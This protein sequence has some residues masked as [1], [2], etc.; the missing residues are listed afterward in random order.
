[1]TTDGTD[2]ITD[3]PRQPVP[4]RA[5]RP[6]HRAE[7]VAWGLLLVAGAAA[8][9][10]S[11]LD[12]DFLLDDVGHIELNDK[13]R[14]LVPPWP[15][16]ADRRPVVAVSLAINYAISELDVFSFHVFNLL[17]H[18]SA[19]L[20]LMGVVRR[21]LLLD[22]FR[23]RYR[24]AAPRIAFVVALVWALHPVQTQAV[25]YVIQ[26]AESL[27]G[28]FYL[29]TF[30]GVLRG[31]VSRRRWGW[32]ALAVIACAL[33]MG[34]KV[35]MITAPG[36]LLI[37]D[38]TLMAGTW[39]GALRRR[40]SLYAALAATWMIPL[41]TGVIQGVLSTSVRAANVGF[42]FKGTSPVEYAITQIGVLLHYLRL[43]LWPQPLCLDYAWP[44]AEG[45]GSALLPGA[46]LVV[47]A[48]WLLVGLWRRAPVALAGLWFFVILAP[49]S[50]I[51]PIRDPLFEHRMYLPLA[52]VILMAVIGAYHLVGWLGQR[53]RLSGRLAFA[54]GWII[55]LA[56]AVYLAW[57]TSDRNEMYSDG[58]AMWNDVLDKRPQNPR[59]Y[60]SLGYLM[61]DSADP[62]LLVERFRKAVALDPTYAEALFNLGNAL[63]KSGELEE[64]VEA[65]REAL[66]Y[67]SAI[68]IA[69][70]NMG[71]ALIGL[72][73][74]DEAEAAYREA[75]RQ[76]PDLA[77]AYV[78]LG[79]IFSG[80][81]RPE[82]AI[83][84][85]RDALAVD[86]ELADAR[87]NLANTLLRLG[88]TDEAIAELYRILETHPDHFPTHMKLGS[89]LIRLERTVEGMAALREAVR[90]EPNNPMGYRNLG[91]GFAHLK[92]FDEA[93]EAFRQ[94]LAI[95]PDYAEAHYNLGTALAQQGDISAAID[96][97]RLAV[98]FNPYDVS[99]HLNLGRALT[100]GGHY[101]QA[102]G[103]FQAALALSPD[104]PRALQGLTDA[105]AGKQ[106]SR[107]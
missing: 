28:L 81:G 27:M 34:S 99:S 6:R 105:I 87:Y 64:A 89:A 85:F 74:I 50:S 94:A 98:R 5:G 107:P 3:S 83:A 65:F 25:T 61:L 100:L 80:R 103:A 37:F 18:L 7:V 46:V 30:Y 16:L 56:S 4:N 62:T 20:V 91:S 22:V 102:I 90:V 17:V 52:G 33:G 106:A 69:H 8:A 36:L 70:V 40:W 59:A 55:V 49:T 101:D 71:N 47:V 43:S 44:V 23:D 95:A 1:M 96:E 78:N 19:S 97:L 72:G 31:A 75:I 54:P 104:H 73:R 45:L 51:V 12:G 13:I 15:L 41:G 92:R 53:L 84:T 88:E 58:V 2:D 93:I 24:I 68:V 10:S 9:Y 79:N 86:P 32:Y 11:S 57:S 21:T 42:S 67:K 60:N 63:V 66:H 48:S 35:V 26:R 39:S 38:R 82:E 29:T 14:R 77:P 76:A